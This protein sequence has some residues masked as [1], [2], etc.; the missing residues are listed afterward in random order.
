[1]VFT[2]QPRIRPLLPDG[3]VGVTLY[4]GPTIPIATVGDNLIL[5]S[6]NSK[7]VWHRAQSILDLGKSLL[8]ELVCKDGSA[9]RDEVRLDTAN[10]ANVRCRI[11]ARVQ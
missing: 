7:G 9:T 8:C 10:V 11:R 3:M 4:A 1:V 5:Y 6:T 2:Q